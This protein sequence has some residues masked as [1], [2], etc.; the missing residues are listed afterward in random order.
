MKRHFFE[1]AQPRPSLHSFSQNT[2][3]S[4]KPLVI[5]NAPLVGWK[6]HYSANHVPIF[7][8]TKDFTM[9]I[10]KGF[11]LV[12]LMIVVVIMGI[13]SAYAIPAY[14]NNVTR[15]KLIDATSTLS[16][17]KVRMEQFYQD[18]RTYM[19]AAPCTTIPAS[20]FFG[21]VCA[22]PT[23]TAF[24]I[25]AAGIGSM[26]GFSYSINQSN[27]RATVSLPAGWGSANAAC[28]ITTKGGTC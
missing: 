11:T 18:N 1:A 8:I 25:T 20:A 9:R 14:N 19:G 22:Q 27:V 24:T 12:E 17:A 3:V 16:D 10:Q 28:W 5:A 26:A 6:W 15:G 23:P 13:L 7:S 21:Y 2:L 4:Y